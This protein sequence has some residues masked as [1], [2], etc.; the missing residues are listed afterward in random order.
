MKFIDQIKTIEGLAVVKTIAAG[1]LYG[2][3]INAGYTIASAALMTSGYGFDLGA[4][5]PHLY[6]RAW[7][8]LFF[9]ESFKCGTGY[10]MGLLGAGYF[11]PR[12]EAMF[13]INVPIKYLGTPTEASVISTPEKPNNPPTS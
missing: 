7:L 2:F 11:K 10:A 13:G 4:F 5:L 6:D 12:L 3:L 9:N 1:F 8:Y